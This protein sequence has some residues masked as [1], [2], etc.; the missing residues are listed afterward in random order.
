MLSGSVPGKISLDQAVEIKYIKLEFIE[1]LT[2]TGLEVKPLGIR[3]VKF[4][5]C[6]LENISGECGISFTRISTNKT[7]YR[8]IGYGI[9]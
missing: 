2:S 3:S 8:H 7:A 5:G 1:D 9:Y 4:F 6:A